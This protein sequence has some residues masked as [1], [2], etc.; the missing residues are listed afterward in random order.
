M[1][2]TCKSQLLKKLSY[3]RFLKTI[4]KLQLQNSKLKKKISKYKTYAS[5]IDV[6]LKSIDS[7]TPLVSVEGNDH[8]IVDEDRIYVMENNE[9]KIVEENRNIE[10]F[11]DP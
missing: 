5:N 4:N 2:I 3:I 6:L 11:E 8:E 7:E 10:D 9:H 1:P